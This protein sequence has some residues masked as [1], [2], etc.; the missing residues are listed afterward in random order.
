MDRILFSQVTFLPT[1]RLKASSSDPEICMTEGMMASDAGAARG[2]ECEDDWVAG[3]LPPTSPARRRLA[4]FLTGNREIT[5]VE[6]VSCAGPDMSSSLAGVTLARRW[7]VRAQVARQRRVGSREQ[8]RKKYSKGYCR[9]IGPAILDW[10]RPERNFPRPAGGELRG[11]AFAQRGIGWKP[12]T[13]SGCETSSQ[14]NEGL[15]W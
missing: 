12:H 14:Y 3:L 7:R 13:I 10:C 8:T 4:S 9:C 1:S 2:Q 5:S 6:P 15:Q 11:S